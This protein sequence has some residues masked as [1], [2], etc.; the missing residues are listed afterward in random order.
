MPI[1]F[2]QTLLHFASSARGAP[3]IS[4]SSM[5]RQFPNPPDYGE[6][7][8]AA[9]EECIHSRLN[10]LERLVRT[11][12]RLQSPA[13]INQKNCRVTCNVAIETRNLPAKRQKRVAHR[14]PFHIFSLLIGVLV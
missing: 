7:R 11:R 9:A 6:L 10:L 12:R 13:A 8:R 14:D 2:S 5:E 3:H 1:S 4:T